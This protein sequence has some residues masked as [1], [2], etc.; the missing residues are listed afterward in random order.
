MK[1]LLLAMAVAFPPSP[2]IEVGEDPCIS[3]RKI[4]TF[5]SQVERASRNCQIDTGCDADI[6][7]PL[8]SV[9]QEWAERRDRY[10]KEC[11]KKYGKPLQSRKRNMM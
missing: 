3:T 8:I 7:A 4:S 11:H 10:R 9:V 5:L 2:Q 1:T 6:I